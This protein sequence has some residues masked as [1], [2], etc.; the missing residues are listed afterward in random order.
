MLIDFSHLWKDAILCKG[1]TDNVL[2]NISTV[3]SDCQN[4][5]NC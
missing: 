5:F 4:F 2:S 1:V 3:H